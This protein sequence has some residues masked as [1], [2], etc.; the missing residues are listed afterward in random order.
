MHFRKGDF[1][2]FG[3][4][5]NDFR[6]PAL[7]RLAGEDVFAQ[8]P[9]EGDKLMIDGE[10]G[11]LLGLMNTTLEVRQPLAVIRWNQVR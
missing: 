3:E 4:T 11:P 10:T 2:V 9:V 5:I 6:A 8:L 1:Q 7:L